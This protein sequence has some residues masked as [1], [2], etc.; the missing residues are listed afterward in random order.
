MLDYLR[1]NAQS[2]VVYF[3][4]AAIIIVFVFTFNTITPDQACGGGAPGRDVEALYNVGGETLDTNWLDIASSLTI[5]PPSPDND[6]LQAQYR[7]QQY[8]S[9]RFGRFGSYGF[10]YQS[11]WSDFG[12]NPSVVSSIMAE[13]AM[14]DLIETV[15]VSQEAAKAGVR[16]S[17]TAMSRRLIGTFDYWYDEDTGEFDPDKYDRMVRFQLGS[18]PSR[19]ETLVRMD[20][21]REAMITLLVGG[22][23]ITESELLFHQ[24]ATGN[25]VDLEYAV[26]DASIASALVKTGEASVTPWLAANQEKVATYYK[27][28]AARFDKAERAQVRGIQFRAANRAR[29]TGEEDATEKAKLQ[30]ERDDAR[31]KAEAA[32]TALA[33]ANASLPAPLAAPPEAAANKDAEA[34][35]VATTRHGVA[36]EVPAFEAA[37]TANS[38]H[39][40]TKESGGMFDEPRDR[41]RLGRYPFGQEVVGPIFSLEPGQMSGVIEVDTGF[42][43]LRLESKL[44]AESKTLGQAQMEIATQLYAEEQGETL[45]K[46][47]AEELLAKAKAAADKPLSEAAAAVNAARGAADGDGITASQTG[48]FARMQAGAYG[49]A[50]K[51]GQVPSL[52]DAPELAKAAFKAGPKSPV[53]DQVF[54]IDGGKRLVVARWAAEEAALELDDEGRAAIR[55]KLLR[56]KQRLVYRTWYEDLLAKAIAEGRVEADDSWSQYLDQ[57]R[58]N[59]VEAGGKLAPT[60]KLQP[61]DAQGS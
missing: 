15:L 12:T 56:Q 40:P 53:L 18:S 47:L 5:E 26:V 20:M 51:I 57:A 58:R 3:M 34:A 41:E 61:E 24:K 1:N 22:L 44:A 8:K 17:N 27:D 42:W 9:R 7:L 23:D 11:A 25:K 29:V 48:L 28:N 2:T 60:K 50:A 13:R 19:F 52:G 14:T 30:K 33:G 36:V 45:K 55:E 32:W 39:G 35:T 21:Q 49:P 37:V 4:F 59:F 46:T 10:I 6:D 38:D 16:V 54:E 43:I 31:T